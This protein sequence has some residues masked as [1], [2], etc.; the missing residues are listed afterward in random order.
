MAEALRRLFGNPAADFGASAPWPIQ[1][2]ILYSILWIVGIIVVC[3]PLAVRAYQ[4][5]IS[6]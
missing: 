5:T 2:S 6:D 1:H 4:R 3:A